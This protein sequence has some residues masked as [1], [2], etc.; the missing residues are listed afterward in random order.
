MM[1]KDKTLVVCGSGPGLGSEIARGALRDGANLV[2]AA[3]TEKKLQALADELQAPDRIAIAVTDIR[4]EDDCKN[5]PG[6]RTTASVA[7]MPWHSWP[8]SIIRSAM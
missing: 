1:L 2:L 5:L 6:S 3:R 7:W 4:E 8:P